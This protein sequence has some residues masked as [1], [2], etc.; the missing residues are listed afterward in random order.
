MIKSEK[1]Q[2]E[3]EQRENIGKYPRFLHDEDGWSD[4]IDSRWKDEVKETLIR[5]FPEMTED[6]WKVLESILFL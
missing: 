2:S 3:E 1:T 4:L 5:K 6:E